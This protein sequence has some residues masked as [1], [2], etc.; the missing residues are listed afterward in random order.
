M[1]KRLVRQEMRLPAAKI[2]LVAY[3]HLL[4]NQHLATRMYIISGL[5]TRLNAE[6]RPGRDD[7]AI[8]PTPTSP[9]SGGG[10]KPYKACA[11]NPIFTHPPARQDAP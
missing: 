5:R 9:R 11:D 10:I 2:Q 7:G 3:P 1:I 8:L 6:E 4:I